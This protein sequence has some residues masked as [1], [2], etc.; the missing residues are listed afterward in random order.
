MSLPLAILSLI[1]TTNLLHH[2]WKHSCLSLFI[3]FFFLSDNTLWSDPFGTVGFH[4]SDLYLKSEVRVQV[5]LSYDEG[6]H[7][8][9]NFVLYLHTGEG[10]LGDSLLK[11]LILFVRLAPLQPAQLPS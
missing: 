3:S 9:I 7:L 4:S 5:L 6:L 10:V 8:V 1:Y 11:T 2:S